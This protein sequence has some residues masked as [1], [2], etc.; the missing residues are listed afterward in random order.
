[1]NFK[2]LRINPSKLEFLKDLTQ[3]Y[4]YYFYYYF[5]QMHYLPQFHQISHKSSSFKDSTI[6]VD[7]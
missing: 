7:E 2:S 6:I 5:V 1:M 3:F 4:Y